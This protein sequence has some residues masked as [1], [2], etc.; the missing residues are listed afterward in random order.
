MVVSADHWTLNPRPSL[1]ASPGSAPAVEPAN[2]ANRSGPGKKPRAP[3]GI[4]LIAVVVQPGF[5][6]SVPPMPLPSAASFVKE[7]EPKFDSG[8]GRQR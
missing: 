8:I 6:V 7:I 4:S 5:A 3:S 1:E 2:P